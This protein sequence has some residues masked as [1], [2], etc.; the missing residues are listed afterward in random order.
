MEVIVDVR[1]IIKFFDVVNDYSEK[2]SASVVAVAGEDLAAACFKKYLEEEEPG[3]TVCIRWDD[4]EP[5][6]CKEG[7]QRRLDRWIVVDRPN[8]DRLVFQTEIKHWSAHSSRGK[9]ISPD[10]SCEELR[11][12]KY[13]RWSIQW[14]P[15]EQSLKRDKGTPKYFIPPQSGYGGF[16]KASKEQSL[17]RDKGR[18]NKVH[19]PT[20]PPPRDLKGSCILPLIIYWAP[21]LPE[22]KP[23][24]PLF[25]VC[26][27]SECFKELWV[28]SVSSYLRCIVED[29]KKICLKMPTAAKRLQILDDLFQFPS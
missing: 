25:S 20:K 7:D 10:A 18:V 5:K 17:K 27:N 22:C 28:F 2:H 14:D 24:K 11:E 9:C 23:D 1:R 13:G 6:V 8:C 19:M 3:T 29:K 26:T 16:K 4:D 12:H 21:M 15:K